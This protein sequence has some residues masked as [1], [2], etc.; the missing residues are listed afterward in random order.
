MRLALVRVIRG[1]FSVNQ[2]DNVRDLLVR[3][4]FVVGERLHQADLFGMI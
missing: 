4:Q 1:R 2:V 3:L